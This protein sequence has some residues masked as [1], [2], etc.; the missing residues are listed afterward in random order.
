MRFIE[1]GLVEEIPANDRDKI[2]AYIKQYMP[3]HALFDGF[4]QRAVDKAL[5]AFGKFIGQ[6]NFPLEPPSYEDSPC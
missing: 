4:P 5:W 3:F 1:S 2:I 6:N